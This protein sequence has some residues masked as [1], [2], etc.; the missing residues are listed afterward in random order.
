MTERSDYSNNTTR[1]I[2][3]LPGFDAYSQADGAFDQTVAGDKTQL[4][5]PDGAA[6]APAYDPF[7]A[8]GTASDPTTYMD[9]ARQWGPMS[10]ED[11]RVEMGDDELGGGAEDSQEWL[12]PSATVARPWAAADAYRPAPPE[13][14]R[15]GDTATQQRPLVRRT[16]YSPAAAGSSQIAY[17]PQA[18][19]GE[20]YGAAA[21]NGAYQGAYQDSPADPPA[22]RG[23]N[24][25]TKRGKH[26]C[27]S[28]FLWLA[29]AVVAGFV[30]LRLIPADQANG[31][32]VPELVSFVPFTL[33]PSAVCLVLAVL[34]RRK[35]LTLVCAAAL[36]CVGW[37][38]HGYFVPT[39]RV[40]EGAAAQVQGPVS[41][42]DS[43]ARVMTL[44]TRNGNA[45]AADIVSLVREQNVEVLCLQEVTN[46]LLAGLAD[47]GIY[48]VL[49][50]YV[51][52][53]AASEISNGGR[54]AI[55]TMA[56]VSN[57]SG[58]LLPI[59]TSSMPAASITVGSRTV[60]VVSVHPNSP[61][62]GA[63][64]VWDTGLSV[65]G[66]LSE[67]DHAYLLMGD[68]N[69]TWDHARF[70][71]LLGSTFADAGEKSGEGFHMTY[72]SGGKIPS[73]VEI[74]HIVYSKD[75]GIVVSGLT[76]VEV[77]GSDHK[78]LLGTLEAL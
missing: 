49:P 72:P 53:D 73:L 34:W 62:R 6:Q 27:L 58:N 65:I 25:F 55:F 10:D 64:D 43:V 70:R 66:S 63:Q 20:A 33:V 45:S 21:D 7:D 57:T 48:E 41:T 12:T 51:V 50:Y 36:A 75:R 9:D 8:I 47:A 5:Q 19:A 68:F 71:E 1:R 16:P 56:P 32:A 37:W 14:P 39:A 42:A 23:G 61:V 54:N 18:Q 28:I 40:S 67:Y 22:R 15:P 44:N 2:D 26:G 77:S 29:M 17:G 4:A 74:D 35:L 11:W 78:A 38:H 69:S 24:W 52:S 13:A 76:A 30:A 46:D 59:Q 31:R 3:D 60:R